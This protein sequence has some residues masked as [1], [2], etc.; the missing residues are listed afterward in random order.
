MTDTL[1]PHIPWRRIR[2]QEKRGKIGRPVAPRIPLRMDQGSHGNLVAARAE[3]AIRAA[4]T[5]RQ[6]SG[7]DPSRLLVLEVDFLHS[8]RRELLE[9]LGIQTIQEVEDRLPVASP[10]Y[11]VSLKFASSH[12]HDRFVASENA[13]GP[14]IRNLSSVRGSNGEVDPVRVTVCF[15][16]RES[17]VS[18]WRDKKLHETL[19]CEVGKSPPVKV[20]AETRFRVLVEFGDSN[21]IDRFRREA[22]AYRQQKKERQTL[23]RRERNEL[24]DA[25]EDVREVTSADRIGQRLR[26][27]GPP[28]LEEFTVDVDLWHPGDPQ[29]LGDVILAFRDLVQR[30]GG[31]VT[32][33][34]TGVADTLLLARVKGGEEVLNAIL[35]Y[36]RVARADLPPLPMET[37]L[38]IFDDVTPIGGIAALPA[39]DGPIACVVDSG[40]VAGHPLLAGLVVDEHDFD[41]G[42]GTPVDLAGHGTFIAGLVAYGDVY[43]CVQEKAWNPA[44]WILSA[45]VLRNSP[46]NIAVFADDSDKRVETQLREAITHFARDRGCRV[47]NLSLGHRDR[48]YRNGR[49][50]PWALVLDELAHDLDVVIVVAAGNVVSPE[51]PSCHVS[52]QFQRDVLERLLTQ[53]HALTDPATA[54]NVLTVGAIT[55]SDFPRQAF[56]RPEERPPIVGAPRECPAPFTRAGLLES[57][58]GGVG[59]PVKPELVAYGGNYCLGAAGQYWTKNDYQLG[60]PSLNH[61]FRSD[62]RL[63]KTGTGTSVST[64]FVS[65]V[66]ALIEHRLRTTPIYSHLPSANLIRALAVHSASVAPEASVWVG[67][68]REDAEK[69]R[70]RLLGYGMPDVSKAIH[71]TDQ[72]TLLV[73]EDSV[74]DGYFHVYELE[75]PDEFRRLKSKRR[76]RITLAYDSPVKGSRKEYLRRR[77]F[78]RLLRASSLSQIRDA[79][80]RGLDLKQV[81]ISPGHDVVKGSTVQSSAFDGTRPSRFGESETGDSP[82]PW[83]VVVRSEPRLETDQLEPQRYALVVSLEHT[84]TAI[85]IYNKV[86]ERVEVRQRIQWP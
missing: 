18:F 16:D 82:L 84:E 61:A 25:I 53:D 6:A 47:F 2:L 71:S 79:A 36:D 70:L 27:E 81:N 60:E 85:R 34:P 45:K 39:P 73:A 9:K 17:A 7:M 40:V 12:S 83:H 56:Q 1:Y 42:E 50:L 28:H 24:F 13:R 21:A 26:S 37:P 76:I 3:D 55:R 4:M 11:A 29:L 59:R 75:L 44:V 51:I 22:K 74:E 78:F 46:Q 49:Q 62:G 5:G 32:D 72:R 15:D 35:S 69:R 48:Q 31:R 30:A 8:E 80:S 68:S 19:E 20:S 43:R 66:C 67:D 52:E 64:A 23:L 41:S 86:R 14:G 63:L 10:Y 54:I 33:G 38:T 58:G 57:T 77:L 65:H